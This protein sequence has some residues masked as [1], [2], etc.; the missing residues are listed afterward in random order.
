[1]KKSRFFL[2]T[3]AVLTI[4]FFLASCNF[5]I[6]F[7]GCIGSN[8]SSPGSKEPQSGILTPSEDYK[9]DFS[10]KMVEKN[11]FY[12][13]TFDGDV[14]FDYYPEK[15]TVSIDNKEYKLTP[16]T[17]KLV[18]GSYLFGFDEIIQ[19]YSINK[20]TYDV[21]IYGYDGETRAAVSE[22]RKFVADDDYF[23]LSYIDYETGE[24][25][26]AMDKE[27]NWTPFY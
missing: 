21:V 3:V 19:M 25:G 27:S 4:C 6:D 9:T 2:I 20:G 5:T 1:M 14:L 15:I 17:V 22:T 12:Y 23:V 11:S 10:F 18:N 26:W 8:G 16:K 24:Q 7:S 13:P